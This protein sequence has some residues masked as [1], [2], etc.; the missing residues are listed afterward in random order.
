M[1]PLPLYEF[2]ESLRAEEEKTYVLWD[3]YT[4]NEGPGFDSRAEA[5]AAND[6]KR[7]SGEWNWRIRTEIGKEF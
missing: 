4:G 1:V 6:H 2:L 3:S 5:N 7:R